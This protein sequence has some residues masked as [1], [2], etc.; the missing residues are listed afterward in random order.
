[1]YNALYLASGLAL[2]GSIAAYWFFCV[3]LAG[4]IA[5]GQLKVKTEA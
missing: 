4:D 3:Q 2:A 1:M 5:S